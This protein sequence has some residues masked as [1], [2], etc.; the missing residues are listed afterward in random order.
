MMRSIALLLLS[1]FVCQ[2]PGMAA[3]R[4]LLDGKSLTG[5]ESVGDGIWTVLSDGTLLGERDSS[6]KPASDPNQAWLYTKE[7]FEEFDL[8]LEW[9]TRFRG[10]SGISIRDNSRARYASGPEANPL[11]TPARIGHEIQISNG[12]QDKYPSGSLYLFC[13]AETAGVQREN[14][15]NRFDISVRKDRIRIMLNGKL[16][17]DHAGDPSRVRRA[18]IGLQ[19]HDAQSVIMFRNIRIQEVR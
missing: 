1:I 18:P 17:C 7:E 12:Y 13:A 5:W 9:W 16:V 11:K 15:W 2:F 19:L 10:N 14:N 3:W 4:K 8:Q 6:K